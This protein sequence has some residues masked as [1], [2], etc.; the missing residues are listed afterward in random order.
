MFDAR[1]RMAFELDHTESLRQTWLWR[2]APKLVVLAGVL[3]LVG[4]E[5]GGWIW[6]RSLSQSRCTVLSATT[7]GRIE[8]YQEKRGGGRRKDEWKGR[9]IEETTVEFLVDGVGN[10]RSVQPFSD[11]VKGQVRDCWVSD[12]DVYLNPQVDRS[13]DRWLNAMTSASLLLLGLVGLWRRRSNPTT[14]G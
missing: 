10:R 12:D 3:W 6:E 2:K 14:A 1:Y 8:V 11:F 5:L 7:G 4:G 13:R 9:W